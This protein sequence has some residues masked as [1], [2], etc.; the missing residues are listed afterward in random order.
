[1]YVYT[2]WSTFFFPNRPF[3]LAFSVNE[4]EKLLLRNS[5]SG[6][7]SNYYNN[8]LSSSHSQ[9]PPPPLPRNVSPSLNGSINEF[10]QSSFNLL[11][12]NTSMQSMGEDAGAAMGMGMRLSVSIDSADLDTVSSAGSRKQPGGSNRR[13]LR[14]QLVHRL[15]S[16]QTQQKMQQQQQ[17]LVALREEQQRLLTLQQRQ[18]RE[19]QLQLEF[20]GMCILRLGIVVDMI[21]SQY[22]L[23]TL[24]CQVD[25]SIR[26]TTWRTCSSS[27][28]MDDRKWRRRLIYL[29]L[30]SMYRRG[31]SR[32]CITKSA[33]ICG[34][35]GRD[36]IVSVI[37]RA[38][39]P[40]KT[41]YLMH[42]LTRL[43]EKWI[44]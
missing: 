37:I 15:H 8:G 42:Y 24:L 6:S 17:E 26:R 23:E 34:C 27:E 20:E 14:Q 1:M 32:E 44:F 39:S 10:S 25:R 41:R 43:R 19:Q 9:P 30:P 29:L 21:H 4:Q 36:N 31:T 40:F 28:G 3:A 11:P 22:D 12:H 5:S 2:I 13:R 38:F 35:R 33:T 18:E 7:I 16:L